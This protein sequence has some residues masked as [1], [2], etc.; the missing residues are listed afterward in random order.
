MKAWRLAG[1]V[2][3]RS[4]RTS[5]R[6]PTTPGLPV[7][8]ASLP[9]SWALTVPEPMTVALIGVPLLSTVTASCSSASPSPRPPIVSTSAPPAL[10]DALSLKNTVVSLVRVS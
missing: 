7:R 9:V 2:R 3:S 4:R 6:L 1:S 8:P 5:A 10:P